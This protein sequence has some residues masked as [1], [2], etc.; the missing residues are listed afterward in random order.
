[1]DLNQSDH[2]KAYGITF[3]AL[4]EGM[5]SD[6]L[7]NYRGGSF[8]FDYSESLAL[9]CRVK[10]VSFENLSNSQAVQ[11]YSLVQS[12]DQNMEVVRLEKA[13]EIAVYVPPGFQPWDD[14]V[15]LAMEYAEV[16]YEKIWVE[17]ILRGDLKKYDWLHLHHEDFTGQYGKFYASFSGAQWYQEQQLLYE[18]EAKKLGFKKV[19]L[20]ELAVVETIK[21]YVGH[22]G[23]LFAMCSATDSY[24]IALAAENIDIVDRMYDGDAP[25]P[26]A[27]SKLNFLNTF[28]FENFSIEMNPYVYEYSDIDIQ[29]EEIGNENND[30]FT[31]FEFSAKYDPV[32]T[33]LTQDHVNVVKGFMGQTTM[34]RKEL[35]KNSVYVLGER[36][37]SDQVKYIHGNFG[38]GTFTFYGGHDPEDYRHAVGD[39][40]TDLS[41]HKNSPGYRLILNN[42]LFPAAKK[43]KQKT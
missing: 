20:M 34:F 17:E 29:P 43:K 21:E 12:E 1:M 33:M 27:Q 9:K 40:P 36:A 8:M 41:L 24:D 37:G 5:T 38:R 42:I 26:D 25:D 10:G 28:A 32:P 31:L 7:L 6:W 2:L 39:P 4:H 3:N 16:P 19:S 30:Y 14:A 18:N 23:F 35:I 22:G 13:P 15:T 11:I